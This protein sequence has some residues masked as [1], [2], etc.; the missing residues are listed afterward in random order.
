MKQHW[1]QSFVTATIL[2]GI[3]T[4]IFLYTSGYRLSKDQ[5]NP[6]DIRRTGMISARSNPE[7][8]SVYINGVLA[9]VTN[10]TISS[11]NPGTYQLRIVKSGFVPWEKEVEV[12]KELV[13]DITAVLISQSTRLEPL[14]STGARNHVISPTLSKLAFFSRDPE[15]SGIWVLNLSG[16]LNIFNTKSYIVFEDTF[17]TTFSNGLSI[18]W[19]PDE[20]QLLMEG[21][22]GLYYLLDIESETAQSTSSANNIKL[23]WETEILRTHTNFLQRIDL[24]E[25]MVQIATSENAVW[26]PDEKKFLYTVESEETIEYRVYNMEKPLPIGEKLDSLVFTTGTSDP[27]PNV[28]WYA[29]SFH[30]ILTEGNIEEEK[31][32]VVSIIR[33]DGTNKTEIYSGA[34]YDDAVYSTPGGDKV[35]VLT[36]FRSGDQTDLYTIG[37]R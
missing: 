34:L 9:T 27:Q 5:D 7:N 37:I 33:I 18:E 20:S 2:L 8:A 6:V 1:F 12:F 11:L 29:D 19:A 17:A 22:N 10:N 16:G 35:I 13:T 26:S 25:N 31:R 24:P 32:G 30:L 15:E 3:T 23:E 21:A 28:T 14:T 36:S 4:M